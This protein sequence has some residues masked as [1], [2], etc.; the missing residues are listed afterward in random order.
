MLVV[1]VP[2]CALFDGEALI[3]VDFFISLF[4]VVRVWHLRFPFNGVKKYLTLT[5]ERVST[6]VVVVVVVVVVQPDCLPTLVCVPQA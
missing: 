3:H 2:Y 4:C 6:W 1:L 5:I